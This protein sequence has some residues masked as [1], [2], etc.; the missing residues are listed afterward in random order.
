MSRIFL[1]EH[2]KTRRKKGYIPEDRL[3]TFANYLIKTHKLKDAEKGT[4]KFRRGGTCAIISKEKKKFVFITLYGSTGWIIENN[5]FDGFSC[6]LQTPERTALARARSIRKAECE[7]LGIKNDSKQIK[8]Q[9]LHS[10]SP[11]IKKKIKR[12]TFEIVP[13]PKDKINLFHEKYGLHPRFILQSKFDS[14][15][16]IELLNYAGI[17]VKTLS[18]GIL[19]TL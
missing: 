10:L 17:R 6:T 8:K 1:T 19:K 14:Y 2:V 3:Y 12:G 7:R 4:Y 9:A 18:K 11:E 15:K 5:D 13:I 16:I